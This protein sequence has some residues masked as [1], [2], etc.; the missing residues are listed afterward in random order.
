MPPKPKRTEEE[1]LERKAQAAF[2]YRRRN[3]EVVNKKARIL[4]GHSTTPLAMQYRLPTPPEHPAWYSPIPDPPP[5]PTPAGCNNR[6]TGLPLA[7][8]QRIAPPA[9][10]PAAAPT[11]RPAAS[12][13]PQPA[14]PPTRR[15]AAPPALPIAFTYTSAVRAVRYRPRSPVG[16]CPRSPVGYTNPLA[17][18]RAVTPPPK[19]PTTHK[20]TVSP[21]MPRSLSDIAGSDSEGGDSDDG[22][23]WDGDV[24]DADL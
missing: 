13:A 8:P 20:K 21:M 3:R 12:P 4:S 17:R 14:A 23:G 1:I 24:E 18:S 22:R 7:E 6:R 16:Y 10:W 2:E 19:T 5:T 15:P 9:P 11:P